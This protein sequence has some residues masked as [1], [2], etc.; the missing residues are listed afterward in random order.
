MEGREEGMEEG[1]TLATD[2]VEL[3][4]VRRVVLFGR[5]IEPH[6][7]KCVGVE[8]SW[9]WLRQIKEAKDLEM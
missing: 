3:E 8:T 7:V 5:K 9:T 6:S 1:R 2:K 4:R